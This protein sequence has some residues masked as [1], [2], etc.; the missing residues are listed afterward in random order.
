MDQKTDTGNQETDVSVKTDQAFNLSA[1]VINKM[2][3]ALL[4]RC[5]SGRPAISSLRAGT[6]MAGPSLG[7]S[8]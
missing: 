5:T 3:V 7:S 2:T 4:C 6:G 8:A 1:T